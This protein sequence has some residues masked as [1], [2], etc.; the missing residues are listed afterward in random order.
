MAAKEWPSA[1]SRSLM[2]AN[3]G[4]WRWPNRRNRGSKP[5]GLPPTRLGAPPRKLGFSS[6]KL[7]LRGSNLGLRGAKLRLRPRKLGLPDR[8]LAW[9]LETFVLGVPDLVFGPPGRSSRVPR[10]RAG[11]PECRKRPPNRCFG[12]PGITARVPRSKT[13]AKGPRLGAQS[14]GE[15]CQLARHRAVLLRPYAVRTIITWLRCASSGMKTLSRERRT[16][17]HHL[18]PPRE[19]IVRGTEIMRS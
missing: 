4:S 15:P 16:H 8:S 3:F 1:P 6:G 12:S 19:A 17:P 10:H 13:G 11:V 7:G 9:A 18:R 14:P 5:L 2:A